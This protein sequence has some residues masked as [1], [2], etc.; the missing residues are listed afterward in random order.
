MV[1]G[2][3]MGNTSPFIEIGLKKSMENNKKKGW[4]LPVALGVPL[5]I[6]LYEMVRVMDFT[7]I[8]AYINASAKILSGK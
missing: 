4:C 6:A 5:C 3:K 7:A 8:N 2:E 1:K